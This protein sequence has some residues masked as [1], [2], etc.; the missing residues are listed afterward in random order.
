MVI[1]TSLKRV[2]IITEKSYLVERVTIKRT[3]LK[4]VTFRKTRQSDVEFIGI[5]CSM[6]RWSV[7]LPRAILRS[8][9]RRNGAALGPTDYFLVGSE[10]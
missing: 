6:P 4:T 7:E 9:A 1:D 2:L 5:R 8:T 10:F 3:Y